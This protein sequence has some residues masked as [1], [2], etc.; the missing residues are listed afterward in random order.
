MLEELDSS[1]GDFKQLKV[2][3]SLFP[4]F[5]KVDLRCGAIRVYWKL[6]TAFAYA[7]ERTFLDGEWAG[8]DQRIYK[9]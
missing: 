6:G 5:F 7:L 2:E 4:E 3:F 1:D 8:F 9:C